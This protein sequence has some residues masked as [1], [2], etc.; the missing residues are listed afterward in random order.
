MY[1]CVACAMKFERPRL[2]SRETRVSSRE[3]HWWVYFEINYK[4]LAC[5]KKN[6]EFLATQFTPREHLVFRAFVLHA[7]R[8]AFNCMK[9]KN[10][11]RS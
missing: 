10:D 7:A 2:F 1:T 8:A 3:N 4:Q 5:E 9:V 11:Y 6:D